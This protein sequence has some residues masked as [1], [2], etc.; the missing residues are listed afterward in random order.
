MRKLLLVICIISFA[1][2]AISESQ[3]E[4]LTIQLSRMMENRAYYDSKKEKRIFALKKEISRD[5]LPKVSQYEINDKIYEEY[6]K[7]IIDSAVNYV[8]KNRDL[9]KQLENQQLYQ[10]TTI[11]LASL[12]STKGMYIESKELL[13]GINFSKLSRELVP[14]YY[15]AYSNFYS[16]YGQSN[17]TVNS[18][19]KSEF[20]RDS[21]LAVLPKETLK[22]QISNAT[23]LLY[24]G[25][26]KQAATIFLSLLDKTETNNSEYATIAYFLGLIYKEEGDF[27]LQKRFFSL[28]AIKDIENSTKDNASLQALALTYYNAGNIDHAYRFMEAAI[29]DAIFCNVRYRTVEN[30]SFYPIINASFQEKENFKKSTLREYLLLIS[31]LSLMLMIGIVYIY[32]QMNKLSKTKKELHIK[33]AMLIELNENLKNTNSKLSE[34]NLI[35]EEYIAH[36]FYI[37]SSYIEKIEN[38]RKLL[39]KKAVNNQYDSL[40]EDLKSTNLVK[41]ELEELY[42]NFDVIFLNLYPNF[43]DEFN[44]L[45]D[46]NEVVIPKLGEL[47][48]TELRIFA[49]IRLGITD[50]MKI[51]TF[52]RYSLRTVYN[53]RTKVRNKA[54]VSR[55]ELE[56]KVKKIAALGP[57]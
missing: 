1:K 6:R 54:A 32:L 39:Y 5:D 19:H 9:T 34:S 23:K 44:K 51:A 46:P 7:Y 11:Q 26:T 31:I 50:S 45:L 55:D 17:S 30:S 43:V 13:D 15:E 47:L 8:V 37:C 35:K 41:S 52:L 29:N 56:D 40:L 48:N 14:L 21:L 10:K 53:Y 2:V 57:R 33:N 42:R 25:E 4:D 3:Q 16:H 24:S 22:Y 20:Y 36:F 27:E 28:S 38:Y 49:L 12:Y 18:F